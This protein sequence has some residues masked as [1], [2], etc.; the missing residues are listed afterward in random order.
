MKALVLLWPLYPSAQGSNTTV[1]C[2]HF[3]SLLH[4]SLMTLLC[5]VSTQP[6]FSHGSYSSSTLL[7]HSLSHSDLSPLL[8][9]EIPNLKKMFGS[10]DSKGA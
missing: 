2:L 1:Q 8:L 9:L 6:Q 7:L 5:V 10:L 3:T 4:H